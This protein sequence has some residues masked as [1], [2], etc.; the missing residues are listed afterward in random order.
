MNKTPFPAP[1]L[2]MN[3]TVDVATGATAVP[4]VPQAT[5]FRVNGQPQ[6]WVVNDK[7]GTVAA[8]ASRTGRA[9]WRACGCACR[10]GSGRMRGD[11]RCTQTHA[12]AAR[13]AG[14]RSSEPRFVPARDRAI[15]RIRSLFATDFPNVRG[16][17]VRFEHGPP[18]GHPVQYRLSGSDSRASRSKPRNCG[19]S[20]CRP[21]A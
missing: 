5:L 10:S 4:S 18:A 20:S 8:R 12:G 3:A 16:R 14:A 15:A 11:G 9:R 19:V 13:A 1:L 7:A 2:G 6:G 17:A 21:R